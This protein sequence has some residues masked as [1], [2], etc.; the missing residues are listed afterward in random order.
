MSVAPHIKLFAAVLSQPHIDREQ[1]AHLMAEVFGSVDYIGPTRSFNCTSY[2]Q[3]EMGRG[4]VRYIVSFT[5][6]HRADVLVGAKRGCI[7]LEKGCANTAGDKLNRTINID[8]GY[9]DHHKVVLASTKAAG[10]KIYLDDG[11]YADL[12]LRYTNKSW[13][14]LPWS[15][16]DF[17]AGHYN[18]ELLAI[19]S[20]FM[21]R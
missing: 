20:I 11:I 16:P 4:L 2:Y 1:I 15:F 12:A 10:H 18:E 19:R 7:E 3:D 17:A 21:R 13:Q 6:P 14:P 9:L 8:I 5:G